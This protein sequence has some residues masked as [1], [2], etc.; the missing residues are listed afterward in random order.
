MEETTIQ[1]LQTEVIR[2][3]ENIISSIVLCVCFEEVKRERPKIHGTSEGKR[4]RPKICG[5][6]EGKRERS[7]APESPFSFFHFCSGSS[8]S[9][10]SSGGGGGGGADK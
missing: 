5:T 9:S 7:I 10:S 8:S 6:S 4:E 1:S 2:Y 3:Q